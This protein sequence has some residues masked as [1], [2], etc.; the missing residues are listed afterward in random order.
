V[1]AQPAELSPLAGVRR[2][3][4]AS[5]PGL[6]THLATYGPL[7]PA[8]GERIL[9]EA[10]ASGLTGRGGAAFP[11]AA[12]LRAVARRR[13]T[14]VVANAAEGEPLSDKDSCLLTLSPHLVLDGIALAARA[15]HARE[16][17]LVVGR[18]DLADLVELA[19]RRRGDR[20]R[21]AVVRA[22]RRFVAGEE[23]AVVD[24]LNGGPGLPTDKA[25]K[26]FERGVGGRPTLVDNAET[27]AQLAL[28]VRYG[29]EWFRSV[30]TPDEPGTML[31]TVSGAVAEPGVFEVALGTPLALLLEAARMEDARAVLVGGFHGAWVPAD[32]VG[33][34]CLSRESLRRYDAAP[35][36]GVVRVLGPR[37][38]G[39][40]VAA[41]VTSY[42]AAES[43]GQCGPC[44][45]GLPRISHL[46][47]RLARGEWHGLPEIREL[48]RLQGLVRNR[49]AC[50]HPDGSERFVR[51]TLRV[52]AEEVALHLEGGCSAAAAR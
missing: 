8:S 14:V 18:S 24:L 42:L 38:C 2:L 28:V 49:G 32:E 10:T 25:V 5:S 4:V 12:K 45:N 23:S 41:A 47:D 21:V 35:G 15:V 26:V 43:A 1:T 31:T 22:R 3:L 37:D 48:E 9:A 36:A 30:G 19:L 34:V 20:V 40:V 52:F 33:S 13:R 29:A 11:T 50:S 17:Y 6:G 7:P 27:L 16:A 46:M 39:L 44:V 51:S